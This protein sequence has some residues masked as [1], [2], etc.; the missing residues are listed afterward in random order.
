MKIENIPIDKIHPYEHNARTHPQDQI[1]RIAESITAY[2]FRTPIL[3]DAQNVLIAGHG[4]LLAA[5]KLGMKKV[6]AL[7]ADDLT[8]EQIKTYRLADNKLA[9]LSTWDFAAMAKLI[10]AS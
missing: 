5:Q 7:R 1:D 4:R 10:S 9:E 8:P 3:I 2:G 6:P